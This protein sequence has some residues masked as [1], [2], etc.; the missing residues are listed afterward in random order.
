MEKS[1]TAAT[2]VRDAA[3]RWAAGPVWRSPRLRFNAVFTKRCVRKPGGS[4]SATA[5]VQN[6]TLTRAFPS[7]SEPRASVR[8]TA[9]PLRAGLVMCSCPRA[10]RSKPRIDFRGAF[11]PSRIE[12]VSHYKSILQDCR[13][14]H[15]SRGTKGTIRPYM[16][17]ISS[18]RAFRL[19][20]RDHTSECSLFYS[21]FSLAVGKPCAMLVGIK[22]CVSL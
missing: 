13:T 8:T 11:Y 7:R 21:S 10:R 15:S 16:V 22:T 4:C 1:L 5:W 12:R 20:L 18:P 2:K 6:R 19:Q 17:S 3:S 14:L 9:P